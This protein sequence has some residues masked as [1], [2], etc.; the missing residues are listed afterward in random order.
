MGKTMTRRPSIL[1]RAIALGVAEARARVVDLRDDQ[2][3]LIE[4]CIHRALCAEHGGGYVNV[5]KVPPPTKLARQRR[6]V[7][8]LQVGEAVVAIAQREHVSA[9]WVRMLRRNRSEP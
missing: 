4:E 6:I 8:S 9:R 3:A 5:A 1:T 7:A 2:A